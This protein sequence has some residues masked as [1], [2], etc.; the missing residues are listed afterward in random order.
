MA[1]SVTNPQVSEPYSDLRTLALQA[2]RRYGDGAAHSVDA[3][4]LLMFIE[5]ANAIIDEVR[6]H[7]YY[8]DGQAKGLFGDIDYYVSPTDKRA[9]PDPIITTGLLFHYAVQQ[10]SDTKAQAYRAMFSRTLS[11]QLLLLVHGPGP[12]ELSVVD[13]GSRGGRS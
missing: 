8:A 9:I 7:P 4:T 1:K 13:N 6:Q 11:Q 5:F 12:Y 2:L 10:L 3:D